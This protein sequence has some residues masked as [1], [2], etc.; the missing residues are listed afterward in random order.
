MI[1]HDAE[2]CYAERRDTQYNDTQN[3]DIQHSNK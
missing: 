3:N 2:C 1:V